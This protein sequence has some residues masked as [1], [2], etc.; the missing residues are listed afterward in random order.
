NNSS[1]PSR[2]VN[3]CSPGGYDTAAVRYSCLNDLGRSRY[4]VQSADFFRLPIDMIQCDGF[5]R[6][7]AELFIEDSAGKERDWFDSLESAIEAH[8]Q[9]FA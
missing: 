4:A 7:F 9:D 3:M 5:D 2:P 8:D 6:Q 1:P